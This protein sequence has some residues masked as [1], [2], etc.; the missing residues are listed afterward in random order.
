MYVYLILA[1]PFPWQQYGNTPT[2]HVP[3]R[4]WLHAVRTVKPDEHGVWSGAQCNLCESSLKESGCVYKLKV[5]DSEVPA[6]LGWTQTALQRAVHS[7]FSAMPGSHH[8]FLYGACAVDS[9]CLSWLDQLLQLE[10]K[11][12]D[13]V[14]AAAPWLYS[15]GQGDV[16]SCQGASL[17]GIF[18]S[19]V[20]IQMVRGLAGLGGCWLVESGKA[21]LSSPTLTKKPQQKNPSHLYLS[22]LFRLLGVTLLILF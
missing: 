21:L 1:S 2:N 20:L 11:R 19:Q 13:Y 10:Q 4:S 6:E 8:R 7:S 3:A 22:Y 17:N 15:D 16:P 18:L 14:T 5:L 12:T 9:N